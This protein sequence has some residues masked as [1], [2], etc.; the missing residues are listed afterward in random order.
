MPQDLANT[1]WAFA[2]VKQPDAILFAA[3]TRA[4]EWQMSEFT[5][6]NLANTAWAF[7]TLK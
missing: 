3:F 2:T 7:A 5:E 6:Q 4:V 1:A